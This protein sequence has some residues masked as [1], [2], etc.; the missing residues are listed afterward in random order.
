[1]A[2]LKMIFLF[3]RWDV[4]IPWRVYTII[5]PKIFGKFYYWNLEQILIWGSSTPLDPRETVP[6]INISTHPKP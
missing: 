4:L 2:Y 1:M 5:Y 6:N 3:P